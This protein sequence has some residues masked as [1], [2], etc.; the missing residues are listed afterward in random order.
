MQDASSYPLTTHDFLYLNARLPA[1]HIGVLRHEVSPPSRPLVG[2]RGDRGPEK[3]DGASIIYVS[4]LAGLQQGRLR[5]FSPLITPLLRTPP[6]WHPCPCGIG[7][8][9]TGVRSRCYKPPAPLR[10]CG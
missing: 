3:N 1:H 5:T 4:L 10:I 7:S 9:G 2:P 6:L 8:K